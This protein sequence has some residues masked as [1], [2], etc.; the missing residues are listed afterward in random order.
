MS[1]RLAEQLIHP[2]L[3][4]FR[5]HGKGPFVAGFTR[6]EKFRHPSSATSANKKRAGA[7]LASSMAMNV[8]VLFLL[9]SDAYGY[10]N[11]VKN[12]WL[13][14]EAY[15]TVQAPVTHMV[16]GFFDRARGGYAC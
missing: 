11:R 10:L 8:L 4:F 7:H 12:T 15:E 6:G 5:R 9:A 3:Q 2:F 16:A 14:A 1:Q 13:T